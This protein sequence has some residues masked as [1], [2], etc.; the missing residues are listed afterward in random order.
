MY[1]EEHSTSSSFCFPNETFTKA[2]NSGDGR[3]RGCGA[4]LPPGTHHK[5]IYNV[6]QFSLKTNW[7]LTEGFLYN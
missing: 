5:D 3:V 4:H 1:L 7:N 6:E 2:N